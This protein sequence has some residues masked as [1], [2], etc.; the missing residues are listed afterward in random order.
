MDLYEPPI[1]IA[2][3]KAA[4]QLWR[5]DENLSKQELL[6]HVE[7]KRIVSSVGQTYSQDQI[8][9][10]LL[11]DCVLREEIVYLKSKPLWTLIEACAV[12]C[13]FN[14]FIFTQATVVK[15]PA[16]VGHETLFHPQLLA[17]YHRLLIEATHQSATG[18]LPVK[19]IDGE[20]LVA[21]EDFYYW[22]TNQKGMALKE[23]SPSELFE[24]L[25]INWKSKQPSVKEP[26]KLE[27]KK[28]EL[29]RILTLLKA[30][31]PKLKTT[32]MP[33]IKSDFKALCERINPKM[34]SVSA[35]T[36]ND[37]LEGIC[38]FRAGAKQSDYYQKVGAN[39]TSAN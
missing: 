38:T 36:F 11:P 12:W 30:A 35:S 9:N 5:L 27:Q 32:A 13:D 4:R 16:F 24:E 8:E 7:I 37:Y 15:N 21:P 14:P 1:K 20:I 3:R 28:E 34:F 18:G 26:G 2:L 25:S 17:D 22:A 31:D 10:W 23:G 33:G 19:H 29:R 39:F 6:K